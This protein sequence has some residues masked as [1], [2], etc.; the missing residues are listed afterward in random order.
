MWILTSRRR[1]NH[2]P[3][4]SAGSNFDALQRQ[5]PTTPAIYPN[6][7]AGPDNIGYGTNPVVTATDQTGFNDSKDY[8]LNTIFSGS[9]KIPGVKGL[10][11]SSYYAYDIINGTQKTFQ[12][13]WTLYSLD[14]QAYL[15]AGN[16]GAEDGSEF[17]IGS[18]RGPI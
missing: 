3:S 14:T 10:V 5:Y 8:Y 4:V 16:T 6:G 7:L 17:L 13:P 9:L 12:K 15:A 1:T 11:V 2:Y 18:K